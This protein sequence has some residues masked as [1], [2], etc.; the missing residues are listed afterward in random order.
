M[1]FS[2]DLKVNLDWEAWLRLA[3]KEG[4][5]VYARERL[6]LHRIHG[7]SETSEGIRAGVRAEEDRM[8]FEAL[9]PLPVARVLARA[10]SLSYQSGAAA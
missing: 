5:F 2:E 9:W 4:A 1:R 8:M 3:G 7:T 10:Y 6:M